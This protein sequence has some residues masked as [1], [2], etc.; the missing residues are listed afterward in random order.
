MLKD[1]SC[2]AERYIFDIKSSS[3]IT[4]LFHVRD[5]SVFFLSFPCIHVSSLPLSPRPSLLQ[6]IYLFSN[7]RLYL[8]IAGTKTIFKCEYL[9]KLVCSEWDEKVTSFLKTKVRNSCNVCKL[10]IVVIVA[11]K[12]KMLFSRTFTTYLN[13]SSY[14]RRLIP[15]QN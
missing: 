8:F 13:S 14:F 12:M 1:K 11:E 10:L 3:F 9:T 6:F 7:F 15:I 5:S 2:R 4:P